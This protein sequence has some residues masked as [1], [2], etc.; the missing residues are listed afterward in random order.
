L[1]TSVTVTLC[2]LRR[3]HVQQELAELF[4]ASQ[5]TISRAIARYVPI[6]SELLADWVPTVE[7]LD[8]DAQLIIDGALLP[9]WSWADHPELRSGKH[10]TTGLNVQVACTPPAPSVDTSRGSPT[11][12]QA[13]PTMP[14]P[15]ATQE[16]SADRTGHKMSWL[17]TAIDQTDC[18]RH[19][20]DV[21]KSAQMST[22]AGTFVMGQVSRA[23]P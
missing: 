2:Y 17:H 20:G 21:V 15:S 12:R 11:P 7:D 9:C 19:D 14:R 4:G 22:L 10:R 16:Y 18:G 1:F 5:A 6:L 8:P 3:N 13:R 23:V